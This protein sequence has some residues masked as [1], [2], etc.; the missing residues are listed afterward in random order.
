MHSLYVE[1]I[2]LSPPL[3]AEIQFVECV[4]S[5]R[6]SVGRKIQSRR[7]QLLLR[8]FTLTCPSVKQRLMNWV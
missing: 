3:T 6:F 4:I 1:D 2:G 5:A 7:R 8:Q